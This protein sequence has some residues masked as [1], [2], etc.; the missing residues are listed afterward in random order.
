M[1]ASRTVQQLASTAA[2]A[3]VCSLASPAL[4]QQA[5]TQ[6]DEAEDTGEIIVT[7]ALQRESLQKVPVAVSAYN[8]ET[9][10][11]SGVTDIRSLQ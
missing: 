4:A 11:K 10:E 7:A 6:A 3:I 1:S 9:L 5:Q 8:T 2:L